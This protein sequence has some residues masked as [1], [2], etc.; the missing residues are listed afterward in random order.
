[1]DQ[2]AGKV[3]LINIALSRI[4]DFSITSLDEGTPQQKKTV[5][6]FNNCRRSMLRSHPWNFAVHEVELARIPDDIPQDFAYAFQLPAD[7]LRLLEVRDERRFKVQGR[8]VLSDSKVCKV[9][10]VRDV[11]D[12][13]QWD[14]SFTDAF[15]YQLAADMTYGVVGQASMYEL[16]LGA[17]NQKL[18]TARHIDATEDVQEPMDGHY[19]EV[20]ASRF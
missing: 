11:E 8:R 10:Y 1:M 13:S 14:A 16:M 4:G 6:F 19:S 3:R 20:Y 2:D 17:A 18:K 7:F 12:P 9:R 15:T 5:T